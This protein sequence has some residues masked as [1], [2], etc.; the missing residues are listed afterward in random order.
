MV[1]EDVRYAAL[2]HT[3]RIVSECF[4]KGLTRGAGEAVNLADHAVRAT[5]TAAELVVTS[6]HTTFAGGAFLHA[7]EHGHS[8]AGTKLAKG[9][10]HVIAVPMEEPVQIK[11]IGICYGVCGT[12][13]E[14]KY[15]S[16]YE[17]VRYWKVV[18]C[19]SHLEVEYPSCKDPP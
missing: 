19:A 2:R 14:V 1:K 6:C 3:Q 8:S 5:V 10:V 13:P 15:L 16:P 9:L 17:F 7:V 12:D 4:A 18:R 11:K